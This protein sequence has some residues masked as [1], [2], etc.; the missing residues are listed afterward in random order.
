M[1]HHRRAKI[2]A[3]ERSPFRPYRGLAAPYLFLDTM[4]SGEHG[5]HD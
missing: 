2:A 4:L 5:R 3:E 1:T